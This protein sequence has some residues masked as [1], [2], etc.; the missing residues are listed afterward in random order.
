MPLERITV[1]LKLLVKLSS[2]C[3]SLQFVQQGLHFLHLLLTLIQNIHGQKFA[4]TVLSFVFAYLFWK[5]LSILCCLGTFYQ[6]TYS[7]WGTPIENNVDKMGG[8][9]DPGCWDLRVSFMP[10]TIVACFNYGRNRL[11]APKHRIRTIG[12]K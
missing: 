5:G 10:D 8:I 9:V 4:I 12:F 2:L 11:P 6:S 7:V 1:A 3:P